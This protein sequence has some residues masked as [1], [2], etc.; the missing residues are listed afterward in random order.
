MK[1][2]LTFLFI[3]VAAVSCYKEI[4]VT[5][6][7][8]MTAE[9][10]PSAAEVSR[11]VA[12]INL[13]D[14]TLSGQQITEQIQAVACD[15][16]IARMPDKVDGMAFGE[17]TGANRNAWGHS[18]SSAAKSLSTNYV[19]STSV[20]DAEI[21]QLVLADL[22]FLQ[23]SFCGY[24][25]FAAAPTANALE[26]LMEEL[27]DP[28][29]NKATILALKLA[30][31]SE[32]LYRSGFTDCIAARYGDADGRTDYIYTYFGVWDKMSPVTKDPIIFTI[33][34]NQ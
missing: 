28:S 2:L 32:L 16:L 1:K 15:L 12:Y 8:D 9:Y 23:C 17:W 11:K 26:A 27:R 14:E 25:V 30:A 22:A 4:P 20:A 6:A 18:K 21:Q 7:H 19:I 5:P 13:S 33:Q 31:P 34:C 29:A 10:L 3:L 24:E